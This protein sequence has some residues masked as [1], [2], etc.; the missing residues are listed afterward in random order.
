M[1]ISLVMI[2]FECELG[3]T[4]SCHEVWSKAILSLA[5]VSDHIMVELS[6]NGVVLLALNQSRVAQASIQFAKD[7]FDK[8]FVYN[9][10]HAIR[11]LLVANHFSTLFK[12][13]NARNM[14]GLRLQVPL[15]EGQQILIA[16]KLNEKILKK[17]SATF[18]VI[19]LES[20]TMASR[21]KDLY[22]EQQGIVNLSDEI[23]IKLM[24]IDIRIL[25]GFLATVPTATEELMIE[26]LLER[27][28]FTGFSRSALKDDDYLRQPMAVSVG[29]PIQDLTVCNVAPLN[30]TEAHDYTIKFSVGM[31][32]FRLFID[33]VTSL[34]NPMLEDFEDLSAGKLINIWFKTPADP[35]VFELEGSRLTVCFTQLGVDADNDI[36]TAE[37]A[38]HAVC[39]KR[40]H[41]SPKNDFTKCKKM[42][43]H[44][45]FNVTASAECA[46]SDDDIRNS[47][48]DNGKPSIHV[49]ELGPTQ[50]DKPKSLFE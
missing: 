7:F 33:L 2:A 5:T 6:S 18:R 14:D 36:T 44:T 21:Y 30:I 8:L 10:R 42:K 13:S 19:H 26:V 29:L 25:K 34:Q 31:K 47:F 41:K 40:K 43:Q 16:V 38:K 45:S 22:K 11:F 9:K 46:E 24:S 1:H 23:R 35:V 17:Y 37:K 28:S 12:T 48:Q 39:E 20:D 3:P 15:F 4:R 27:V 32:E 50:V 49:E